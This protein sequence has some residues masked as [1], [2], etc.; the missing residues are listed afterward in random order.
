MKYRI[1]ILSKPEHLQKFVPDG[2][3]MKSIERFLL[4]VP[5][6]DT[7]INDEYTSVEE[8]Y[9][10]IEKNKEKVKFLQLTILPVVSIDFNGEIRE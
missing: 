4:E 3:Y 8:A 5:D 10:A 9:N 7:G 6:Y 1:Y 2:Y